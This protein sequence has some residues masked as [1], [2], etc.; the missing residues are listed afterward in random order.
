MCGVFLCLRQLKDSQLPVR[1]NQL[2]NVY[3]PAG[4]NPIIPGEQLS[5][6]T[7]NPGHIRLSLQVWTHESGTKTFYIVVSNMH[8]TAVDFSD[9]RISG[10]VSYSFSPGT[11]LPSNSAILIAPEGTGLC[12]SRL[13]PARQHLMRRAFSS[14]YCAADIHAQVGWNLGRGKTDFQ[15]VPLMQGPYQFQSGREPIGT[16][17]LALVDWNSRSV[18]KSLLSVPLL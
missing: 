7:L 5:M 3:G 18:V 16:L 15:G 14:M 17:D 9:W 10:D 4:G 2:Y 1:A 12:P 11:V 8:E 6:K 13:Q